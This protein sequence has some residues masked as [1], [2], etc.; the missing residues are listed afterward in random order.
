VA[1]V[2]DADAWRRM[3]WTAGLER[4]A[5]LAGSITQPD[6]WSRAASLDGITTILHLAALV[7]HTRR[8]A[9]EVY[10]SN[11]E[12]TLAMV[13]LAATHRCRLV[14]VSTSGTVGCFRSP[15]QTA[16]EDAPHCEAMVRHWP[17]YHSKVLAEREARRL[18]G[19]LGVELVIVRP[20]V[21]LGPGDHK[22]RS[23]A[24]LIR[25][26]RGRLPFLIPGGIHFGD[27]RDA[28]GALVA[29]TGRPAARPVYHLVGTSCS[30]EQFFAMAQEV[31]GVPAPRRVI[32]YRPAWWL[33]TVLGPL[34]VLPDPVVVELARH[35]WRTS[36]RYA[37]PDLGYTARDPKATLRDTVAWLRDH[38]P[39]LRVTSR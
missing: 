12:G 20:P 15:D 28:A 13:R 2:R 36:S 23:T 14:L 6:A 22:F 18:A 29:A 31:S 17:Y 7:R 24:H 4:V 10:R 25:Y 11:V 9:A 38:H 8:G 21:L 5:P 16:D 34:G 39:A 1:L 32:P 26:L 27:V 30:I 33:A 37:E 35:Y 19:A 3:D